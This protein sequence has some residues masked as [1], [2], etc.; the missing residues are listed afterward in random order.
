[1][2]DQIDD[3]PNKRQKKEVDLEQQER[4]KVLSLLSLSKDFQKQASSV[5]ESLS[6]ST[7]STFTN[8]TKLD[9]F[10]ANLDES[11][12]P[13]FLPKFLP[14]L[15]I[16]FC[17]KNNFQIVPAVISEFPN[18]S[19]VSFKS[20][21]LHSIH[22]QSLSTQLK[23]LI[24]TD[25][26]ITTLPSTIGKCT[27]LQKLMLS[28]NKIQSI[29]KEMSKCTK[30]ELVRL[31]SNQLDKPP[32]DLLKLPNL[33]WIALSENPFL[34]STIVKQQEDI[35]S[36]LK[37]FPNKE[38]D[39]PD[40]GIV[41]GK[42]ASGI[43]RKYTLSN[44]VDSDTTSGDNSTYDVAVKEFYS[45]ITSDGNPQIERLVSFTT[46]TLIQSKSLIT[47]LGQTKKN[48]LV[49]ELLSDYE[50]LAN[51]P[52]L[53]SCSRDVYDH[54]NN[55]DD[56]DGMK[57]YVTYERMVHIV[58]HLLYTLKE[59]HVKCSI[60]HGDFYGHNILFST[61]EESQIWLTDF[62]AAFFYDRNSEYGPYIELIER[63]AFSH[64]LSEVMDLTTRF[65]M[66]KQG[67]DK[68]VIKF[69]K[70]LQEL[71]DCCVALTFEQLYSKWDS[72]YKTLREE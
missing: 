7:V 16:L 70:M 65:C 63:R 69:Q 33:A 62:G 55:D 44:A 32:M 14:N 19:M 3:S 68:N 38:L 22:P 42:G 50:V 71:I 17:M 34:H 12:F 10:Q 37:V 47:V 46:A 48:N 5:P 61:K 66:G 53:Q 35:S 60:T 21:K 39:D 59:L 26:Q 23:W 30:L 58:H 28:G 18:L 45:N 41:L 64:L 24:L 51:P 29:P 4:E 11:S 36:T 1:M 49:M 20:N 43:T 6:P 40:K 31:S 2:T 56:K 25:N 67:D 27:N 9:L 52:S 72:F 54:Y 8:L 57:S 15:K 13:S